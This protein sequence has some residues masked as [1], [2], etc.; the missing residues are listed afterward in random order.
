MAL[1]VSHSSATWT[2]G[3]FPSPQMAWH[4]EGSILRGTC[5][6]ELIIRVSQ[7]SKFGHSVHLWEAA[8][9]A[10]VGQAVAGCG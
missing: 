5:L 9:Q 1:L 3:L 7:E 4:D 10:W 8:L 6:S 2:L